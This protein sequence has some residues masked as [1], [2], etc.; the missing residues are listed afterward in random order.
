MAQWVKNLVLSPEQLGSLLWCSS[1]LAQACP[2]AVGVGKKKNNNNKDAF[3]SL[4][5]SLFF[6]F[7]F[8]FGIFRA[9]SIAYGG[10]Q[11]R[12]QIGTVATGL[13]RS[14]SN[15]RSELPLWPTPQL[16]ATPD[17][18]PLSKAK[19]QIYVLMDSSQI[20]FC[21]ATRE[22]PH[23]DLLIKYFNR[24]NYLYVT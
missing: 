8:F 19:D 21:W 4:S 14:H 13:H 22:T 23:L 7:F 11:A 1:I 24:S 10:S 15:A 16:T 6:F 9:L 18:N 12:G 20:H 5:L 17:L 2:H 3:R